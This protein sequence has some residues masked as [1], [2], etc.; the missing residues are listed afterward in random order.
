MIVELNVVEECNIP[1]VIELS[2]YCHKFG[3]VRRVVACSQ[4]QAQIGHEILP[5]QIKDKLEDQCCATE[6]RAATLHDSCQHDSAWS[7]TVGPNR[8]ERDRESG[9]C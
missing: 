1:G 4:G 3:V 6:R 2:Q 9:E 7:A 8:I 5:S